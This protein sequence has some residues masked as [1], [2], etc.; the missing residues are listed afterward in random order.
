MIRNGKEEGNLKRIEERK[1][2]G[3]EWIEEV[4]NCDVCIEANKLG[5]AANDDV[6]Q[7]TIDAAEI[8]RGDIVKI[9]PN[10]VSSFDCVVISD[11]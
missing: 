6:V 5:G 3:E 11:G 9:E 10:Q 4:W 7:Y 8:M 1:E 2:K